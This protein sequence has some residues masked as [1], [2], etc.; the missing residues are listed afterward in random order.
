MGDDPVGKVLGG[1]ES[2]GRVSL[3]ERRDVRGE[4]DRLRGKRA[5]EREGS[6]SVKTMRTQQKLAQALQLRVQLF[7]FMLEPLDLFPTGSPRINA[8][9][10]VVSSATRT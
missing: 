6:D 10:P 9:N 5:L 8:D 1:E 2:A 3:R 7:E 4:R